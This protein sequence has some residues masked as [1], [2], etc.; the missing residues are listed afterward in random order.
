MFLSIVSSGGVTGSNCSRTAPLTASLVV[1]KRTCLEE[2][3]RVQSSRYLRPSITPSSF[4]TTEPLPR[5]PVTRYAVCIGPAAVYRL[6]TVILQHPS[7]LLSSKVS[8]SAMA[9][10]LAV[11]LLALLSSPLALAAT[12]QP[13]CDIGNKCPQS[14]PCCSGK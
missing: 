13:S 10:H 3:R 4:S 5:L 12:S 14:A 7:T 8:Q 1:E 2:P 6:S 9:R 11:V